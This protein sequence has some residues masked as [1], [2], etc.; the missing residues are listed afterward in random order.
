MFTISLG[1]W[2]MQITDPS[3]QNHGMNKICVWTLLLAFV[4]RFERLN[5]RLNSEMFYFA[6]MVQ[7]HRAALFLYMSIIFPFNV[8]AY[9]ERQAFN[10]DDKIA[11]YNFSR[12]FIWRVAIVLVSP[13]FRPQKRLEH[14]NF[15]RDHKQNSIRW[16]KL[17]AARR[18]HCTIKF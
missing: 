18:E 16:C 9:C 12:L 14:F 4:S 7:L 11:S 10:A 13:L 1:I 3:H 2:R 15:S 8:R 6:N 5:D 17:F